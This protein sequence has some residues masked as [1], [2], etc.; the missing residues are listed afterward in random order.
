VISHTPYDSFNENTYKHVLAL[1]EKVVTT[2]QLQSLYDFVYARLKS[3]SEDKGTNFTPPRLYNLVKVY[4]E[5]QATAEQKERERVEK[6]RPVEF[7]S[8]SGN[9][10][11]FTQLRLQGKIPTIDYSYR[12][13]AR[14]TASS[15]SGNI[16]FEDMPQVLRQKQPNLRVSGLVERKNRG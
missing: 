15:K 14:P 4:P 12:E 3:L 1:A 9:M 2:E 16:S 5:W 6:K 7:V 11:N 13:V 8:G 10:T